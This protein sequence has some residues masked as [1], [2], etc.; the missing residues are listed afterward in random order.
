MQTPLTN[1]L[2]FSTRFQTH[3]PEVTHQTIDGE[4]I[5]LNLNTGAYYSMEGTAAAIWQAAIAAPLGEVVRALQEHYA[6]DPAHIEAEARRFLTECCTE[7]LLVPRGSD[8]GN[9]SQPDN[10]NVSTPGQPLT[11][12]ATKTPFEA[13]ALHRYN[14]M[15]DLLLLDPI[16]E[17]DEAGWPL[18]AAG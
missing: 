16:H 5:V 15:T 17:V 13:P 10:F 9:G 11:T 18:P 4:V 12:P 3:G 2:T 1:E 7:E 8:A 14:D 6:A